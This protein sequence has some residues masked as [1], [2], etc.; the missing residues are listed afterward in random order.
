[1]AK[2]TI[3]IKASHKGWLHKALGVPEGQ[4]IPKS[5]LEIAKSSSNPHI[6]QMANFA[7][8]ARRWNHK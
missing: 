1:M 8:N 5:K 6:R 2:D 7:A 3:H 4:K